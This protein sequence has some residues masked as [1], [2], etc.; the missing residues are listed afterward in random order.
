MWRKIMWF[1]PTVKKLFKQFKVIF[2]GNSMNMSLSNETCQVKV[3]L[4]IMGTFVNFPIKNWEQDQD[5]YFYHCYF[6][7][8]SNDEMKTG[9]KLKGRR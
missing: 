3:S 2:D 5:V 9:I 1:P 8:C 6:H 4:G 7:L